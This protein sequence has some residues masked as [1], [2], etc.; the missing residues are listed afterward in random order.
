MSTM[1]NFFLFFAGF[2][3]LTIQFF[4]DT[5]KGR[6]YL[7]L[8]LIQIYSVGIKSAPLVIL[9]AVSTG[10]VMALQF[11][12]G[13]E[14]FG[15][16]LYVPK[17]VGITVLREMGPVFTSLMFAARVGAGMAS[18]IGSMKVT[19]Q[20]D[21]LRAL[22]TSPIKQIVVPRVIACFIALPLLCIV[23][24]IV[25]NGGALLV[26]ATE[27]NIDSDFYFLK[28][29]TGLDLYDFFSGF[30]KSFFFAF[31]ISIS[32]CYFGLNVKTG[33][34]E[35]GI[36]TTKAVVTSSVFVLVGDYVLTKAFWMVE[37]W[38]LS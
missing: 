9:T 22:G 19:Q 1:M 33:T 37:K 30:L 2:T 5:F 38:M 4:R 16:K 35:V 18:E 17:L 3:D 29:T 20:I 25:S 8:L 28:L 14:K 32:S 11:G 6:F 12:L 31:F 36:A 13:L 34:Q 7:R 23:A 24:N 21:A 26:G 27:L 15:G 10:S